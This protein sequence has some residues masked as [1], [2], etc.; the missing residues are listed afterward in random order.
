ML[1]GN[2]D[3]EVCDFGFVN[4]ANIEKGQAGMGE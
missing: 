1:S 3:L 2:C 4:P